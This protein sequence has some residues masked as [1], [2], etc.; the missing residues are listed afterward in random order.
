MR[1]RRLPD[2]LRNVASILIEW[3]GVVMSRHS[4]FEL[5]QAGVKPTA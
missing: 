3:Y 5:N 4:A 1:Q 2:S